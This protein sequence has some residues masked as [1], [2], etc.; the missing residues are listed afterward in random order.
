MIRAILTT[1]LL[2]ILPLSASAQE[3]ALD[4][5]RQS[6]RTSPRDFDAQ[7]ALGRALIEAGHLRE[8]S[9]TMRRAA[10]LRRDD[11]AAQ[12]EPIRVLFA[13]RN[14]R[15]ARTACRRLNRSAPDSAIGHVCTARAFLAMSR[16]ARAFEEL[17]AALATE[18]NNY[19]ALLALGD[20]HRLRA[21]VPEAEAA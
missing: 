9:Q 4:G 6:A 19:E 21:A 7:V 13:Q 12:Y 1:A 8:A 5:L 14:H 3:G 10:R 17:E 11:P 2:V 15:A 20:A 18:P 16:S